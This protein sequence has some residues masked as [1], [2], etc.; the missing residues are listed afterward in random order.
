MV[1]DESV[2]AEEVVV[3][4]KD[5]SVEDDDFGIV[6]LD[7]ADAEEDALTMSEDILMVCMIRMDRR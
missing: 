7:E 5:M 3:T 2:V 6:E 4:V 1:G